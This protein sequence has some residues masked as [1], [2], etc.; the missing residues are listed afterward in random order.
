VLTG[1][2]TSWAGE[3]GVWA[4]VEAQ[5]YDP[6]HRR[7]VA[8]ARVLYPMLAPR[9]IPQMRRA[10]RHGR[11]AGRRAA[12]LLYV[13]YERRFAESVEALRAELEVVA[14]PAEA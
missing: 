13:P 4:F 9:Q 1:F 3:L 11:E 6:A 8:M 14:F 7:A 10:L 2:D 12:K 5:G